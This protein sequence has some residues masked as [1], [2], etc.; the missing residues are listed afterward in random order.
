VDVK[1][2]LALDIKRVDVPY[3]RVLQGEYKRK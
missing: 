2:G 3:E 1:T